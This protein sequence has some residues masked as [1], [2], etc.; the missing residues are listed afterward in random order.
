M[1][2][3]VPRLFLRS[4]VHQSNNTEHHRD[5]A[6][7]GRGEA[8][9][10]PILSATV[11]RRPCLHLSE[12]GTGTQWRVSVRETD[13]RTSPAF[14]RPRAA[15]PPGAALSAGSGVSSI[16]PSGPSQGPRSGHRMSI[17]QRRLVGHVHELVISHVLMSFPAGDMED[18]NYSSWPS[19]PAGAP[20]HVDTEP[21]CAGRERR[22]AARCHFVVTLYNMSAIWKA[23]SSTV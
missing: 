6:D 23:S 1:F 11:R 2:I 7:S 8:E 21:R 19:L 12:E 10:H 9:C 13:V 15:V 17:L 20:A 3:D 4:V 18:P 5:R 16:P 22:G 14:Q